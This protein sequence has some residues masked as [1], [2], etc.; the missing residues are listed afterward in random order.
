MGENIFKDRL[1]WL[2]F[3]VGGFFLTLTLWFGFGMDQAMHCYTAW[4]WKTYHLPPYIGA[5]DH[6]F[7]G[8]YFLYYL[9]ISIF[10]ESMLGLR[11]FDLI[12][13]L[14]GLPMI[15]YVARKLSGR[16]IAGFLSCAFYGIFYYGL[17]NSD[18]NQKESFIFWFLLVCTVIAF[19][20][21]KKI[22]LRAA[23][24][25]IFLGFVFLLK[26][27][28]GLS[29]P[30]FGIY[31]LLQG[32]KKRPRMVWAELFL[33]SLCCFLLPGLVILYYWDLG[34]LDQLYFATITY[35]TEIYSKMADP[36]VQSHYFWLIKMPQII[37]YLYPAFFLPTLF[38]WALQGRK[39]YSAKDKSLF[40]IL[41]SLMAV[42]VVSYRMQ[43]RFYGYH[44][45]PMV[46]FAILFAGWG[47][48]EMIYS[49]KSVPG[50]LW[51]KPLLFIVSAGLAAFLIANMDPLLRSFAVR[52]CFRS[53]DR[54]YQADLQGPD[55]FLLSRNYYVAAK[56][57]KPLAGPGDGI[58][59]FGPYPLIPYL[60]HKKLPTEI[61]TIH[62]LLF[63]RRDGKVLPF[64]IE[65]ISKFE[66]EIISS[67]PRFIIISS[68]FAV[69]RHT[70]SNFMN[71]DIKKAL[72]E[73]FPDLNVFLSQ[74]YRLRA[75]VSQVQIYEIIPAAGTHSEIKY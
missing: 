47:V 51:E 29:W 4:V 22:W 69:S 72:S 2:S 16:S 1:F 6:I 10:G 62:E 71:R 34:A 23:L 27:Y 20:L 73:N 39:N 5:W 41:F 61:V 30:V 14:S 3:L 9:S 55:K 70:F 13:Q 65:W 49:F 63:L 8:I 60:L 12:F 44:L 18:C 7:P 59:C 19:S 21:E 31:F 74:N 38:I 35:N 24:A 28:Y 56:Y 25:G 36:R 40:W 32:V 57:L 15:F 11:V 48:A 45:I 64:Q 33:F 75:T 26:P 67:R 68:Q 37:L 58:A 17:G 46:S 54:A 53:L 43:G 52:Y 42:S 66:S 50:S